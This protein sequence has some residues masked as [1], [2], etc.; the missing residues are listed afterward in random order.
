[1]K[2]S[3]LTSS[4]ITSN[5][6]IVI[7]G[8]GTGG[9]LS[10]ARALKE[11]LNKRGI[12]PVYIGSTAGQDRKWFENDEGF[13]E[14]FFFETKGVVNQK[15]I[16][17]VFSLL[18]IFKASLKAKKIIKK[19]ATTAVI[20]VGGYSAAPAGFGAVMNKTPLYIHEQNAIMGKL[21]R[22][23]AP[24]AKEVFGSFTKNPIPYPVS[25]TFFKKQRIRSEVKTVIF[26]GGSQGAKFINDFAI[27]IAKELEKR[28]IA[29]IHQTGS[30]DFDRVKKEYEKAGIDADV[31]D[32]DKN[33]S[34]KIAEA[35]FA[36]SRAGASTL[37]EL[38]A[39]ALPALFIPYPYA[40]ADHQYFNAKYL[41]ERNAAFVKRESELKPEDFFDFLETDIKSMSEKLQDI[42]K[43]E[44]AKIIIDRVLNP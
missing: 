23:L 29:I 10:I 5:P 13:K 28:D 24:F 44:G 39:N 42:A 43:P 34:L 9:H 16:K 31:F 40:A 12:K 41:S 27:K 11:E 19:Q 36:V 25:Q 2:E 26:L 22:I 33:I 1:M 3:N 4:A 8:G 32:F 30:R 21:N 38:A 15:G 35:D 20:S 7:A 18:N 6:S 17:K 14:R 37:W